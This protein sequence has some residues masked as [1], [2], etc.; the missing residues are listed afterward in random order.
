MSLYFTKTPAET[1]TNG[2]FG[3]DLSPVT[4]TSKLL[5]SRNKV[6]FEITRKDITSFSITVSSNNKLKIR[7]N[8]LYSSCVIGDFVYINTAAYKGKFEIIDKFVNV[9]NYIEVDTPFIVNTSTGYINLVTYFENYY[10][11]V[12]VFAGDFYNK[13]TAVLNQQGSI[14]KLYTDNTGVAVLDLSNRLND[15][16]L[17]YVDDNDFSTTIHKCKEVCFLAIQTQ[18]VWTGSSNVFIPEPVTDA[19][20]FILLNA[21]VD[22]KNGFRNLFDYLIAS[23]TGTIAQSCKFL[24]E[25]EEPNVWEG[26]PFTLSFYLPTL[27]DSTNHQLNC[28]AIINLL[29]YAKQTISSSEYAITID[30]QN[31]IVDITIPTTTL[32]SPYL[33]VS[34]ATGTA[35]N[36]TYVQSGYVLVGYVD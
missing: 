11:N 36:T 10:I 15:F 32:T 3:E 18:E 20:V 28:K 16:F 13:N 7:V 12:K 30:K 35:E 31:N 17:N 4:W 14:I 22:F 29:N 2:L 8:S 9:Y 34:A 21:K 33:S 27:K 25:F 1:I 26:L 5:P 6:L 23:I 19:N 24:T